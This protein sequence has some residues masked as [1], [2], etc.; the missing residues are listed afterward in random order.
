MASVSIGSCK[1]VKLNNSFTW[2]AEP[3]LSSHITK[4]IT[5]QEAIACHVSDKKQTIGDSEAATRCFSA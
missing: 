4:D 3:V 5:V 1:R 2:K